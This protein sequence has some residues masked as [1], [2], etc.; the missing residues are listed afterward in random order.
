MLVEM[1]MV[2]AMLMA[3]VMENKHFMY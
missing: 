2:M 3:M 1:E